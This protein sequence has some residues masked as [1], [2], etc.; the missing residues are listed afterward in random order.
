MSSNSDDG[1]WFKWV[2]ATISLLAAGSGVVA[3]LTY[4]QPQPQPPSLTRD[5]F[6]G[7]WEVE[8]NFANVSGGTMID[9]GA[10]GTFTGYLTTFVNGIGQ[11]QA[12][13][14]RWDFTKL[15]QDTFQVKLHISSPQSRLW[16]GTFR[17]ID[18]NHIHNID[19]NYVAIRI[20]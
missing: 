12:A 2:T 16:V 9:Y 11:K 19:D 18:E 17:V 1:G 5:F 10:D 6:A 13:T 3:L 4:F 20:K 14:G 8:Q 7:R 15:S